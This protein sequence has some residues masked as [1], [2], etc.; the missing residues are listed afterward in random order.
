MRSVHAAIATL[1][2][3]LS[4]ACGSPAS[5]GR[6]PLGPRPGDPADVAS[7]RLFNQGLGELT[8]HIPLFPGDTLRIEVRM[9]APDG[10]Q[11]APVTGGA[12][13]RFT[14]DP[15]TLASSRPVA[16][17]PLFGDVTGTAA[18]GTEGSMSVTLLFLADSSTKTFAGFPV[19]VH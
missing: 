14:F 4:T 19:L 12:E 5:G 9:Y 8:F 10:H 11:I 15:T 2:A 3:V 1:G 7:V 18:A 16:G 13:A 17:A 6:D